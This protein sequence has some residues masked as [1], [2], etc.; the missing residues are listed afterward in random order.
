MRERKK[1][2][3]EYFCANRAAQ[4][5]TLEAKTIL[6]KNFASFFTRKN[7]EAKLAKTR[8][9]HPEVNLDEFRLGRKTPEL[10]LRNM[11]FL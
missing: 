1:V 8:V 4:F 9:S 2:V 7:G 6:S 11:C 3:R 10:A 5:T